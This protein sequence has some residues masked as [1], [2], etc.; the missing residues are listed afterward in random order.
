MASFTEQC[1][2]VNSST[3]EQGNGTMSPIEGY[4][5]WRKGEGGSE[6]LSGIDIVCM[7]VQP[8]ILSYDIWSFWCIMQ[9]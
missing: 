3:P 9:G 6:A 2:T 8:T 5:P 7:S 1:D 4:N